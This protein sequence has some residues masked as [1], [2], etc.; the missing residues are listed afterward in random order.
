MECRFAMK[1]RRFGLAKLGPPRGLKTRALDDLAWSVQTQ[2]LL[3]KLIFTRSVPDHKD[4]IAFHLIQQARCIRN[5]GRHLSDWT[6]RVANK[7]MVGWHGLG[8]HGACTNHAAV[9]YVYSGPV[10]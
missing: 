2:T 8:Y 6:R 9:T 5:I 7:N 10:Q 3:T 1:H 4:A